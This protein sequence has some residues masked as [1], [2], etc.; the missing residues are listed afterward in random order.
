MAGGVGND[1]YVV[2]SALDVVS[3]AAGEGSADQISSTV[4]YTLAEQV[5]RLVLAGA[6]AIDGTGN[7]LANRIVGNGAANVLDGAG[8]ADVMSGG[9]GNDTYIVDNVGDRANEAAAAGT[10]SVLA[11]VSFVL[12]ANVEN[13]TLTGGANLNATGN[14]HDNVLTGNDGLNILNAGAGADTLAGGAGNDVLRGGADNDQLTGDAG[15]DRFDFFEAPGAANADLITDFTSG[16][17]KVRLDNAAHAGIGALGAFTALDARFFAAAG[18]A[19][20]ADASDRVIYDTTS[21]Q[22]YYDLDGS[23]AAGAELIATLQDHPSLAATDFMV[24]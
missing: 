13:L 19:G 2:N 1:L 4:S 15:I 12:R 14:A 23:G 20:G 6:V 7:G 3:E 21:G 11:S 10:D 17:D 22:L 24:I 16:V 5:E 9:G 8:G 18:A